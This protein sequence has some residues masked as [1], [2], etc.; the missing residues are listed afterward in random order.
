MRQLKS[1]SKTMPRLPLLA[2]GAGATVLIVSKIP[3]LRG[4]KGPEFKSHFHSALDHDH[5][6]VHVTHNRSNEQRG[7]GGWEHLT[8]LHSHRHN[9]ASMEHSHR[10][11]R[12]F[13]A[14][15]RHE[16][17]VHDHEHPSVS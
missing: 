16:A 2:L 9:H 10:P 15:H 4:R 8:A 12:D 13:D 17:H 1:R 3:G 5:E 11:H 6:H 7:V 14:E